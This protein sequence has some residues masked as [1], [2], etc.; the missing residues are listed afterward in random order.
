[1]SKRHRP[2][3]VITLL[4]LCFH[5]NP[6]IS[7]GAQ[8]QPGVDFFP[9]PD[10]LQLPNPFF[11]FA[12]EPIEGGFF[13]PGSDPF[14]GAFE[15]V[16]GIP[17]QVSPELGPTFPTFD[18]ILVRP[19][20]LDIPGAGEVSEVPIQLVALSLQSPV[21]I[22]V[23]YNGGQNPENWAVRVVLSEVNP[24][25]GRIRL[26][27]GGFLQ[28]AVIEPVVL[29]RFIFVRQSDNETKVLD[30][31]TAG[32][33]PI[34]LPPI[35]GS[36]NSFNDGPQI[37]SGAFTD[38]NL[39][40]NFSLGPLPG[41]NADFKLS[42]APPLDPTLDCNNN[43]VF[44]GCDL[45]FGDLQDCDRDG[46]P[47]SCE[48]AEG[49]AVDNNSNGVL[50]YCESTLSIDQLSFVDSNGGMV[51]RYSDYGQATIEAPEPPDDEPLW[52]NL[53]YNGRWA[54]RNAAIIQTRGVGE[55]QSFSFL[56]SLGNMV[57]DQVADAG[58]SYKLSKSPL[59]DQF[60]VDTP[61]QDT[62]VT[63]K[64]FYAGE[65]VDEVEGNDRPHVP[66]QAEDLKN[67]AALASATWEIVRRARV[68]SVTEE[69]NHCVPGAFARSLAW[70]ND[71]YCFRLPE[72]CDESQEIYN[73]LKELMKTSTADGTKTR[74]SSDNGSDNGS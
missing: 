9:T 1:M 67:D 5:V 43:G 31:G 18:S 21:P 15:T 35:C 24:S 64:E 33:D 51:Q 30:F 62:P 20:P 22:S 6:A 26:S 66:E 37:P 68:P 69:K 40:G 54:I 25:I 3:R 8:F 34:A 17:I 28:G 65:T 49:A 11:S 61:T 7:G 13:G 60:F 12:S 55:F 56:F 70:M 52:F 2:I 10:G 73:K 27:G 71:L 39:D 48:I 46:F 32:R 59:P 23:T 63:E 44:D 38:P 57:G 14:E 19:N 41:S 58:V 29:P 36:W 50:D 47:D 72:D 74:R 42:P 4:A 45:I 16:S 53:V